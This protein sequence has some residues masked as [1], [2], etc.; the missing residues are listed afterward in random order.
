MT[1]PKLLGTYCKSA[2]A[3]ILQTKVTLNNTAVSLEQDGI[4]VSSKRATLEQLRQR[5]LNVTPPH[6]VRTDG[7]QLTASS[8]DTNGNV[9][10]LNEDS[11]G[12]NSDDVALAR[13]HSPLSSV[14]A[15]R[16]RIELNQVPITL[17][18]NT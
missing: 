18:H 17:R 10:I 9:T 5:L 12:D 8:V 11:G 6:L 4:D 16:Q 13:E 3:A 1:M 2:I 15:F 14:V 7:L